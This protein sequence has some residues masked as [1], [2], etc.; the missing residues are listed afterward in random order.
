MNTIPAHR[1]YRLYYFYAVVLLIASLAAMAG[2]SRGW[3]FLVTDAIAA[4]WAFNTARQMRSH[5]PAFY[6]SAWIIAALLAVFYG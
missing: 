1:L 6:H 5:A 3:L 2:S 4:A